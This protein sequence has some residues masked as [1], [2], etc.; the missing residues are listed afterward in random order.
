MLFIMRL[1]TYFPNISNKLSFGQTSLHI[2]IWY[3][4][5]NC[6]WL[7]KHNDKQHKQQIQLAFPSENTIL[8]SKASCIIQ[9]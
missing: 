1:S 5:T 4:T 7:I 2:P 6:T 9:H 8:D 3:N